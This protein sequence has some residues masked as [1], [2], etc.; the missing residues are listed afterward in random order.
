M[1]LLKNNNAHFFKRGLKG[2]LHFYIF[3]LYMGQW[4]YAKIFC[5]I[6]LFHKKIVYMHKKMPYIG[7]ASPMY[8]FTLTFQKNIIHL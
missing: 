7:R 6:A 2:G 3:Y 4:R 1:S 8:E 5:P